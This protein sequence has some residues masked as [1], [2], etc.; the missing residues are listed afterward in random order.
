M[1][2]VGFV[3]VQESGFR[4]SWRRMAVEEPDPGRVLRQLVPDA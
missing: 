4:A 3:M 1:V 2:A